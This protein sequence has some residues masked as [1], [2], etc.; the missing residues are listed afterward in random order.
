MA[1]L[2]SGP[3]TLDPTRPAEGYLRLRV[4]VESRTVENA[5]AAWP[6]G[7]Q[8]LVAKAAQRLADGFAIG[9]ETVG[10]IAGGEFVRSYGGRVETVELVPGRSTTALLEKIRN[11]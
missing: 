6:D 4:D 9:R 11:S 3:W 5:N 1:T 7:D 8:S 2:F 10:Q